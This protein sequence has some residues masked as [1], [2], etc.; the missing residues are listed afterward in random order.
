M[1]SGERVGAAGE[2]SP[3]VMEGYELEGEKVFLFELDMEALLQHIPETRRFESLARYPAVFRDLSVVVGEEVESV[4]IRDIIAREGGDLV[5]TV[6]L[7]D[8]FKGASWMHR[9]RRSPFASA[10]DPGKAHWTEKK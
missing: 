9:K 5:E 2:V 8:L 10:I 4:R 3:E 1:V 7:Y 6:S